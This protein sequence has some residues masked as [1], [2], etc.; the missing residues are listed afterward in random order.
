MM[1]IRNVH[2]THKGRTY[3]ASWSVI[4][5]RISVSSAYGWRDGESGQDPMAAAEKLLQEIVEARG[6]D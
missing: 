5:G 4:E 1:Q 3:N 2:I 6:D